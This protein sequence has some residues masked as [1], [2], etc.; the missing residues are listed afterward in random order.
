[1]GFHCYTGEI[2]AYYLRDGN[3]NMIHKYWKFSI[4]LM[5]TGLFAVLNIHAQPLCFGQLTNSAIFNTIVCD[6]DISV[7]IIGGANCERVVTADSRL[8][9]AEVRSGTLFLSARNPL[10][11]R[12][13]FVKIYMDRDLK[14][15]SLSGSASV[16]GKDIQSHFLEIFDASCGDLCIR[17]HIALNRLISSGPGDIDLEWIDSNTLELVASNTAHIHLVGRVDQLYA[18]V[19]D[20]DQLDTQYLHIKKLSWANNDSYD[21]AYPLET[22]RSLIKRLEQAEVQVVTQGDRLRVLMP[23]ASFFSVDKSE[24]QKSQEPTLKLLAKLVMLYGN[25]PVF[26]E[27]YSNNI[28]YDRDNV[29][30]TLQ[31]ASDI[32]VVLWSYGVDQGRMHIHGY[33]SNSSIANNQT[34]RGRDR[35]SRIEIRI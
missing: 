29:K 25:G 6:G 32:A 15:L 30:R 12:R 31:Q 1:M 23:V 14:Q 11:T 10:E 27:G 3:R 13:P 20:S 16:A 26:I 18:R 35:N 4:C 33:G 22:R 19:R 7:E 21:V 24:L 2:R 34:M 8:I 5:I 17:G 9:H 28:G